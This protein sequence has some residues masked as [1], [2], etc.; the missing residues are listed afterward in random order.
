MN[1]V[2]LRQAA[3]FY[4]TRDWFQPL[5]VTISGDCWLLLPHNKSN[6]R[7][8]GLTTQEY[9]GIF[10]KGPFSI[11]ENIDKFLLDKT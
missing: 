10:L 2:L 1:K 8:F 4:R 11:S 5:P 6:A 3:D 9:E 7:V